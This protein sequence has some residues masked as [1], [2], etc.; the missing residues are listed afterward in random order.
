M[1]KSIHTKT[2][3]YTAMF[4]SSVPLIVLVLILFYYT[5]RQN[6]QRELDIIN[7]AQAS[8]VKSI[9]NDVHTV[10]SAA[11]LNSHQMDFLVFCNSSDRKKLYLSGSKIIGNLK[12]QYTFHPSIAAVFLYNKAVDYIY[13]CYFYNAPQSL[14]SFAKSSISDREQTPEAWN[15]AQI[16]GEIYLFYQI[17]SEYGLL[18]VAMNPNK[19]YDFKSLA[20]SGPMDWSFIGH[21]QKE[22][23]KN[24]QWLTT[25]VPDIPMWIAS[26]A[27]NANPIK[28]IDVFQI[29]ILCLIA[30]FILLIPILWLC[31]HRLFLT[32]VTQLD[33][34]FGQVKSQQLGLR[35]PIQSNIIELRSFA[36]NFNEMLDNIDALNKKLYEQRLDAARARLQ[37]LQLQ[38]RPHFYLNCLK[39]MYTQ[40]KLEK[41]DKIGDMILALSNYFAQ[42]FKD[43]RNF[44]SFRDE[45]ETCQSYI[46]LQNIL[47]RH[48]ILSFDIDSRCVNA[49]CLPMTVVTF[50]ENSIKHSPNNSNL[51]VTIT[52]NTQITEQYLEQL[53]ITV[54]N[55]GAFAPDILEELNGANPS[56]MTY[57]HEKIGISNVRYRLW[58]IYR[59]TA[60][61]SFRN[62]NNEAVVEIL[63]P[64][65][66]L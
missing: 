18:T 24:G 55:N 22:T 38:I 61:I 8:V 14:R 1:K 37:F 41:Y 40:L 48:I 49:K 56:E 44:V 45:L 53:K 20:A 34:F 10:E 36:A 7:N 57:K 26:P 27:P 63:I 42:A 13:P 31:V 21:A 51:S 12:E 23:M 11:V 59:E 58:L 15:T 65:E 6:N 3:L 30:I 39:N 16:D 60:K 50:V 35:V 17:H 66:G 43:I 33:H 46:Q 62:E 32:P 29:I 47:E 2:I 4:F 52:A 28:N 19:N 9:A 25:Q 5:L 64:F 54:R